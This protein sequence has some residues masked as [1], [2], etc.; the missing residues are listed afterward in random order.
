MPSLPPGSHVHRHAAGHLHTHQRTITGTQH[1]CPHARGHTHPRHMH[2]RQAH[3][4]TRSAS[5]RRGSQPLPPHPESC[6]LT[7]STSMASGSRE[8]LIHSRKKEPGVPRTGSRPVVASAAPPDT[9]AH[10]LQALGPAPSVQD[11]QRG[12]P[13]PPGGLSH[14]LSP[15]GPCFSSPGRTRSMPSS[16]SQ[17]KCHPKASPLDRTSHT[18]DLHGAS[19]FQ[20]ISAL[21]CSH[22]H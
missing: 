9:S 12:C 3:K 22:L 6:A 2:S 18:S 19:P 11:R 14:T 16:R 17:L 21:V 10:L 5:P 13:F 15:Q 7:S 4:C 20:R 8:N 1:A